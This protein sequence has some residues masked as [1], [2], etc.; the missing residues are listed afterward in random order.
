VEEMAG[1]RHVSL[2]RLLAYCNQ[3]KERI[4]VYELGRI[5]RLAARLPA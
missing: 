2:V 5:A 1:L 3:A 4:L